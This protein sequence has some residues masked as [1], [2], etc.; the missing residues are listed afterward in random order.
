M[1]PINTGG[2]ITSERVLQH[3]DAVKFF[4]FILHPY[5]SFPQLGL[6]FSILLLIVYFV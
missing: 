6:E 3:E 2:T 4:L 1:I 5:A